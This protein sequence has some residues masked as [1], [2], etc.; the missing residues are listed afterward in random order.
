MVS[1]GSSS[2]GGGHFDFLSDEEETKEEKQP[3]VEE[4]TDEEDKPFIEFI[5]CCRPRGEHYDDGI[6]HHASV[7]VDVDS[8]VAF[9]A[10]GDGILRALPEEANFSMRTLMSRTHKAHS[11]R[12]LV[13]LNHTDSRRPKRRGVLPGSDFNVPLE[14]FPNVQLGTVVLA[15]S[16]F[17]LNLYALDRQYLKHGEN[18]FSNVEMDVI[19]GAMNEAITSFNDIAIGSGLNTGQRRQ[20]SH[21]YKASRQGSHAN[22]A[23]SFRNTLSQ[24]SATCFLRAFQEA[25]SVIAAE[26]TNPSE[27]QNPLESERLKIRVA[28]ARSLEH[29]GQYVLTGAGLKHSLT[30]KTITL[31][32]VET[33]VDNL[34][35]GSVE[36]Q[37]G[38]NRIL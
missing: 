12:V 29:S 7:S 35:A 33:Y 31:A 16:L 26:D 10:K 34:P 36:A 9:A 17:S 37:W 1:V 23:Q 2:Q 30:V 18:Y 4:E 25:L 19:V 13:K 32:D 8:V 21:L 22:D 38:T 28:F 27:N 6:L 14:H 5:D 3:D 11:S 24:P 20:S 15:N